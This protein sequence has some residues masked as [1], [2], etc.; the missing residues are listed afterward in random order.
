MARCF[1]CAF[2]H[3]R[4]EVLELVISKLGEDIAKEG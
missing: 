3:G 2:F 4:V 1:L